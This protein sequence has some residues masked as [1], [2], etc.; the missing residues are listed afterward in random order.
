MRRRSVEILVAA[1]VLF[2]SVS[3]VMAG[4]IVFNDGGV[5][6][7]DF[8]A[9]NVLVHGATTVNLVAG[10]FIEMSLQVGAFAHANILGGRIGVM[11]P[12]VATDFRVDENGTATISGGEIERVLLFDRGSVIMNGGLIGFQHWTAAFLFEDSSMLISGGAVNGRR[13]QVGAHPSW[14]ESSVLTIA[15]PSLKVNGSPVDHGVF[16]SLRGELGTDYRV[17]G[18]LQ[19]GDYINTVV[20]VFDDSKLV[21]IPEPCMLYLLGLG[22]VTLLRKRRDSLSA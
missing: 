21:I 11:G 17:K 3:P 19:T 8:P 16:Y 9:E 12:P 1:I 2:V 6:D 7:I 4:L 20:Q 14:Y 5:H 15:G 10:G 13:I 22:G 18:Y